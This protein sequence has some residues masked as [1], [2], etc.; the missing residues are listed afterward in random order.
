MKIK[1]LRIPTEQI[2]NHWMFQ[3][4]VIFVNEQDK[5]VSR[6]KFF[7]SYKF[8]EF[9]YNNNLLVRQDFINNKIIIKL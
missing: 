4:T 6:N 8:S 5:E 7:N 9:V 3:D 2:E 1:E